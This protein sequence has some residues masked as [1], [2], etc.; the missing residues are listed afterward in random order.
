[1]T[2]PDT[3]PI[4]ELTTFD[5]EAEPKAELARVLRNRVDRGVAVLDQVEPGWRDKINTERLDLSSMSWCVWGQLADADIDLAS[6]TEE[7]FVRRNYPWDLGFDFDQPMQNDHG[8]DLVDQYPILQ[9][10]WLDAIT[11][12]AN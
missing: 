8:V 3:F 12:G 2:K 11:E 1:M 9:E 6:V 4:P 10:F 7:S 5:P